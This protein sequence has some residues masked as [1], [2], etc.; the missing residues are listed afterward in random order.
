MDSL[1]T[2]A[3]RGKYL[4]CS[5]VVFLPFER[6][7]FLRIKYILW[8]VRSLCKGRLWFQV[9]IWLQL[10]FLWIGRKSVFLPG[11]L[12]TNCLQKYDQKGEAWRCSNDGYL[13]PIFHKLEQQT[14]QHHSKWPKWNHRYNC[15]PSF[16]QVLHRKYVD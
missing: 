6:L 3:F 9:S 15:A 4:I 13:S 14:K 7:D 8:F 1:L 5:L 2:L 11:I 16:S 10:Y 12:F